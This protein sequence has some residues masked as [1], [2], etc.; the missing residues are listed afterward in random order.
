MDLRKDIQMTYIKTIARQN[1]V[2][3]AQVRSDI[4]ASIEIAHNNPDPQTQAKY[5]KYFGDKIPT[6]EEFVYV[7]A[8][9]LRK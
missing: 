8:K 1:G 2:S 5:R 4:Q 3:V 9:K 6:P 7:M